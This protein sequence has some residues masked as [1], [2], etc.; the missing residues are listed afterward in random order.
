MEKIN[1]GTEKIRPRT[2]PGNDKNENTGLYEASSILL[3]LFS[4]L[5]EKVP[6]GNTDTQ[7]SPLQIFFINFYHYFCYFYKHFS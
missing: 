2:R 1:F 7:K 4:E 3:R 5:Y 6:T